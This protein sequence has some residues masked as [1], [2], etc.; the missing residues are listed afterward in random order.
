MGL[1]FKYLLLCQLLNFNPYK[2]LLPQPA[3]YSEGVEKLLKRLNSRLEISGL[4][5][6]KED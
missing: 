3:R 6:V 4:N 5:N 2:N 1:F